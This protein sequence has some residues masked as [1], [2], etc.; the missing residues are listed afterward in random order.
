ML[1][2]CS[3]FNKLIRNLHASE[4]DEGLGSQKLLD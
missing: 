1:D 3:F 2:A 4:Q